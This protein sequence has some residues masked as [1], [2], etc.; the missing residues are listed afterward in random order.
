MPLDAHDL[1]TRALRGTAIFIVALAAIVLLPAWSL[2]FWQ[3]WLLW[4]VFSAA[5]LLNTLYFLRHDPQLVERRLQ[6]GPVAET[7]RTQKIVQSFTSVFMVLTF[8]FPGLDHR[9]GWSQLPAAIV[10]AGNGLVA[11]GFWIVFR[12]LR[13]NSYAAATIGVDKDQPVV[14]TGPYALVRHPMYAGAF[15]MLVG[16]AL[17]LSSAF[18]L[19]FAA[20]TMAAIVWRL[21]D[22]EA[23]L[24]ESL[25]GYSAYMRQ[26]RYRLIPGVW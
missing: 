19:I 11:L 13:E 3:G 8:A 20:L 25:P 24:A 21:L 15:V 26:T 2:A 23:F 12:T 22:E 14:T 1:R 5:T 6:A 17:A 4:L 9:F 18:D 16:T 7:R 10:I